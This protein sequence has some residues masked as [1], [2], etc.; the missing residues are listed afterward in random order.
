MKTTFFK[1][2]VALAL[3][4]A[5]LAC[6]PALAEARYP[7]LNGTLTD[8]ANALGQTMAKDI[9][10]YAEKVESVTGVKLHVALVLFLDGEPAQTYADTL[11]TRWELGGDDLLMLGAA[12]EDTFAL[13]AGENVE[14]SLSEASLK[15]LL[16]S[17]G[18]ADAF[19]SQR[20]DDAFG[21]FF[22]AFNDLLAK[23]YDREIDLDSLFAAYQTGTQASADAQASADTQTTADVQTSVQDSVQSVIDSSSALWTSTMDSITSS[24]QDYRDYHDQREED[25]GGLTPMGWIVLVVIALIIFGQSETARRARRNGSG[26]GCSPIG[27]IVGGLGLGALF[28]RRDRDWHRGPGGFGRPPRR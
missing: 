15:G 11:F 22:V 3:A 23:Q 21:A 5:L 13:S 10:A 7:A 14:S 25:T 27:W 16:Y 18:F 2:L 24:V 12:A 8:D 6:A 17:S 19:K 9:A 20:Y 26:C 28:G 4:L 1:S